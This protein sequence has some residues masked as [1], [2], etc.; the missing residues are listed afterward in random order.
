MNYFKQHFGSANSNK[1]AD[2]VEKARKLS[3]AVAE[4]LNGRIE[5]A[6]TH[7]MSW[8]QTQN[9]DLGTATLERIHENLT[10]D[11]TPPF[12]VQDLKDRLGSVTSILD[13]LCRRFYRSDTAFLSIESS[14]QRRH[15]REGIFLSQRQGV[16][17]FVEKMDTLAFEVS[18]NG[19]QGGCCSVCLVDFEPSEPLK[20]LPCKHMFHGGCL[21][22]WFARSL[23]CP[24]CRRKIR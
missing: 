2:I 14:S 13:I 12:F 23:S 22:Q 7:E 1:A 17:Y 16:D 20:V 24:M 4:I 10:R 6:T 3:D 19:L 8:H 15:M 9:W 18:C 21:S 11:L 5:R